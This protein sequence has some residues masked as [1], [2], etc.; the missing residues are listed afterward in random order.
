[1]V[2]PRYRFLEHVT[3]A[4]IEAYGSDLDEA[5]DNAGRAV[6]DTLVHIDAVEETLVEEFGVE[7][8]TLHHLLYNWLEAI[9]VKVNL[10]D[11]VF[12]AFTPHITKTKQGYRLSGAAKGETLIPEKHRPKVEVKAPTYHLMDVKRGARGVTLRFL[13]DL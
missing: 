13:L 10:E 3:D 11:K 5:F 7:G 2:Q 8:K 1:M 12:R 9:L 4:L 6:M